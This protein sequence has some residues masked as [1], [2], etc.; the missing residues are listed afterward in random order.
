MAHPSVAS[1]KIYCEEWGKALCGWKNVQIEIEVYPKPT[2]N[3]VRF[4]MERFRKGDIN[5]PKYRQ[6]RI[7]TFVNKIYL[8]DDKMAI[9]Y[10]V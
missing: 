7:D 3:E 1:G 5:D 6:A 2:I 4:F 8:C 9:L 10:F